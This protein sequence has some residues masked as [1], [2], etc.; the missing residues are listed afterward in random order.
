VIVVVEADGHRVDAQHFQRL[1]KA[2]T[3][4]QR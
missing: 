2:D 4:E 1:A 3:A